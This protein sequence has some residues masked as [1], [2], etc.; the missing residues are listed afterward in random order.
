MRGV[1]VSKHNKGLKMSDVKASGYEF[2][3]LRVG[4]T[5]YGSDRTK[6]RDVCFDDFYA[7][8]KKAGLLI[9]AYYYS[10]A[11]NKAEGIAEAKFVLDRIKG[12]AF[13][14]PIYID[15]EETRWQ[16]NKK[17]GV[18][19]AI[20]GFCETIEQAGF[21]AGVYASLYWFNHHID[22][23]KLDKWSKWVASWSG[24]KPV[25]NYKN[26]DLWQYSDMGAINGF[27]VDL[28]ELIGNVEEK[29]KELTYTVKAGDTLSGIAKKFNTT[30][31]A[32]AK[33][34]NIKDVNKIYVGQILKI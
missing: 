28:N 2:A 32:L 23:S 25:F 8:A 12:K 21:K 19:D 33:K 20:I 29:P 24:K 3:I 5:G 31:K 11:T 34:N 15:V 26:F 17:A 7:Q 1:D 14:M 6:M 22:T 13:D 18:T 10:C 16:M 4:Y 30:V 9:G 27:R